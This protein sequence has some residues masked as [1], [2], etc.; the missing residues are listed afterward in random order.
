[1]SPG[2]PRQPSRA[3]LI[4]LLFLT[5]VP[6]AAHAQ[7]TPEERGA[8]IV[9]EARQRVSGYGDFT[10]SL[11]VT[12]SDADGRERVREMRILG[13]EVPGDGAKT[14]A[15]FDLPRD[16]RGTSVLTVTHRD[17]RSEQWLYLPA[18][19][20]V[21]RVAS[22]RQ[23]ESFM[24]SEFTYEDL[25][26]H[27]FHGYRHTFLRE[28]PLE[29]RTALVLERVPLDTSSAYARQV[30]WLDAT[31]YRVLRVDYYDHDEQLEKTLTVDGYREY[32]GGQWRADRMVMQNVQTGTWTRLEWRDYAFGTGLTDRDF[33]PQR[34]GR[35]R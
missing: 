10:A 15:V 3:V 14:L 34:L 28:E 9:S 7:G 26:S 25:G 23:T 2:R 22:S 16:L 8:R 5:G 6:L 11:S 17:E 19:R 24:G 21:R 12:L 30:L 29:G 31:G 4:A 13:L 35:P 33:D 1:M 18:I 32:D 20:R 27:E